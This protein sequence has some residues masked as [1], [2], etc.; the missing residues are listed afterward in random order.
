MYQE[1]LAGI[2]LYHANDEGKS[3][4]QKPL[5]SAQGESNYKRKLCLL[6]NSK[7]KNFQWLY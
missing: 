4:A 6:K 3:P 1:Q 7:M 5:D 2:L